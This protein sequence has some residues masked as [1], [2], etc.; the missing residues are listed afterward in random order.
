MQQINHQRGI[1]GLETAMILI[2][3]SKPDLITVD[4]QLPGMNGLE[5]I[6]QLRAWPATSETPII[7][8]PGTSSPELIRSSAALNTSGNTVKPWFT[9][10]FGSRVREALDKAVSAP[11]QAPASAA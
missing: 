10:V 4:L 1:T 9:R 5:L 11:A 8:I 2:A 6:Q 3:L 7:V